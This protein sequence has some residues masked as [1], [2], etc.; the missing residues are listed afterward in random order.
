MLFQEE[1]QRPLTNTVGISGDSTA[2]HLPTQKEEIRTTVLGIKME[3]TTHGA[4]E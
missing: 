4:L 1:E 2:C 3:A